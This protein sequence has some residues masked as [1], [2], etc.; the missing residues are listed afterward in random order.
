M[1]LF[2]IRHAVAESRESFLKKGKE[3]HLRPLTF[4]GAKRMQKICQELKP[5]T[6]SLDM[7]VSSPH[8]RAKQ[9]AIIVAQIFQVKNIVECPEL[10]PNCSPHLFMKWLRSQSASFKRIAAVGH[11]P[12]LGLFASFALTGIEKNFID[13]KKSGII[14]LKVPSFSTIKGGDALLQFSLP[15]KLFQ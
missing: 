5:H 2:L 15:P 12:Q 4:K 10:S 1:E 6:P 13:L 9:T 8:K 3:E 11:E 7:I 14:Y